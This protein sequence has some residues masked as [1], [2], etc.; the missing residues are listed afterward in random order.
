MASPQ[1]LISAIGGMMGIGI[2]LIWPLAKC[3][4]KRNV[5]MAGFDFMRLQRRSAG[6]SQLILALPLKWSNHYDFRW[7]APAPMFSWHVFRTH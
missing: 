3:F 6:F 1:T 7:I 5:T 4:G 2:F